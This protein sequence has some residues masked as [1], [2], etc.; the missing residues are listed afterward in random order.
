MCLCVYTCWPTAVG[1]PCSGARMRQGPIWAA[2]LNTDWS[3][4]PRSLINHFFPSWFLYFPQLGTSHNAKPHRCCISVT[5]KYGQSWWQSF[6]SVTQAWVTSMTPTLCTWQPHWRQVFWVCVL[7]QLGRA[8][9]GNEETDCGQH[10]ED[11]RSQRACDS[12]RHELS[13][14]RLQHQMSSGI[15]SIQKVNPKII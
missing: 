12:L 11:F 1:E 2:P 13:G 3:K 15:K 8:R 9:E 7:P 4:W 10:T 5:S 14:S 6:C